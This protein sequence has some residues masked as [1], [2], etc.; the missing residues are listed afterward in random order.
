MKAITKRSAALVFAAL[1]LI[2]A[3]MLPI[4]KS[5]AATTYNNT[6]TASFYTSVGTDGVVSV[7]LSVF[8]IKSKTTQINTEINVEKKLI[9]GLWLPILIGYPNNVWTDSVNSF[10][11]SNTFTKQLPSTGT[12]R[13]TVTYTVSGSGGSDDVISGYDTVTY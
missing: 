9:L 3:V 12:Y 11:Y 13:V 7:V 5:K 4:E 8:G 1:I 2:T 6:T 10:Y